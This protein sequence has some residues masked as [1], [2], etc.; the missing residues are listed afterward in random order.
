MNLLSLYIGFSCI[1]GLLVGYLLGRKGPG[2]SLLV[3]W[4]VTL[5]VAALYAMW[6]DTGE[7]RD[8]LAGPVGLYGII[9]P[10]GFSAFMAGI[11]GVAVRLVRARS[12]ANGQ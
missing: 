7:G 10:F 4:T 12:A 11:I 8:P 5:V 9:A 1:A 2:W 6:L 3:L